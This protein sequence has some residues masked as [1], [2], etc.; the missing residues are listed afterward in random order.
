M[1]RRAPQSPASA[2]SGEKGVAEL[3]TDLALVIAELG[4]RSGSEGLTRADLHFATRLLDRSGKGLRFFESAESSARILGCSEKTVRRSR[5]KFERLGVLVPI[6]RA[7][8]PGRA[9]EYQVVIDPRLLATALARRQGADPESPDTQVSGDG[10]TRGNETADIQLSGDS[11]SR[12]IHGASITGQE[13]LEHRTS[14]T[15]SPDKTTPNSGQLDVRPTLNHSKE[16]LNLYE[17]RPPAVPVA[18]LAPDA[19]WAAGDPET[20]RKAKLARKVE[21]QNHSEAV[22]KADKA[23]RAQGRLSRVESGAAHG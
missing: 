16:P 17:P 4:R 8:Y 15:P 7:H 9:Y 5:A 21:E 3:K 10:E 22:W 2:A 13:S 1:P 18:A 20:P 19:R 11:D 23:A 6:S 12:E 14:E